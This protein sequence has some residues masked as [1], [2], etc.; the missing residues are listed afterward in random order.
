MAVTNNE[1]R[2]DIL[3]EWRR[4][5]RPYADARGLLDIYYNYYDGLPNF[6]QATTENIMDYH[7]EEDSVG[8]IIQSNPNNRISYWKHQWRILQSEISKY[9]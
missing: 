7:S 1:R 2:S 8:L 5:K 6:K 4:Y 3:E 9:H